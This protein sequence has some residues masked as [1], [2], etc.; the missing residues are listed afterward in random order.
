MCWSSSGTLTGVNI[1]NDFF[2]FF[3][4][5]MG[6]AAIVRGRTVEG[7]IAIAVA[8]GVELYSLYVGVNQPSVP[9]EMYR[10]IL[11]WCGTALIYLAAKFDRYLPRGLRAVAFIGVVSYPLYLIHQDFGN[12]LLK[13]GGVGLVSA[14]D[15]LIRAIMPP[16]LLFLVAWLVYVLVEKRVIKRLTRLLASGST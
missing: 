13:W 16:P 14:P 10:S 6:V 15:L 7:V 1:Y 2:S 12:I 9:I 8:F 11:L 3:I 4:A 5:G